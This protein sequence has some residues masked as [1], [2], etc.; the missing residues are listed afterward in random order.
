[1]KYFTAEDLDGF[2]KS[3]D[4]PT[5]AMLKAAEGLFQ[6]KAERARVAL[7]KEHAPTFIFECE[8]MALRLEFDYAHDYEDRTERRKADA[9]S[10]GMAGLMG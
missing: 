4:S 2:R 7:Y 9:A 8:H 3:P 10:F 5:G 6:R 1:M